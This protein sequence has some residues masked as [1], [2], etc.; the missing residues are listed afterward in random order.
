M[1]QDPRG[2]KGM[3]DHQE[4]G[5]GGGPMAVLSW[6]ITNS[7]W[8]P[9][10]WDSD[11][12]QSRHQSTVSKDTVHIWYMLVHGRGHK[13]ADLEVLKESGGWDQPQFQDDADKS[14][15]QQERC[16][17]SIPP[18]QPFSRW[19]GPIRKP[20]GKVWNVV[21]RVPSPEQADGWAWDR[22]TLG[23]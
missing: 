16:P 7:S 3:P 9:P 1:L 15:K 8:R 10:T 21:F 17:F 18:S 5:M 19:A 2:P 6:R 12:R 23:Q 11:W 4:R 22:K 20:S 14:F 13:E